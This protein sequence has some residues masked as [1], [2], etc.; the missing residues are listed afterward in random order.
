MRS[1]KQDAYRN[2]DFSLEVWEVLG[3]PLGSPFLTE[4][5]FD[6]GTR[7]GVPV[8]VLVGDR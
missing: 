8:G 6:L 1:L 3:H 2:L 7:V 5:E 4:R